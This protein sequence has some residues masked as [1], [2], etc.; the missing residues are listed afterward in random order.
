L[1]AEEEPI[2]YIAL[3]LVNLIY[4]GF[5]IFMGFVTPALLLVDIQISGILVN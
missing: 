3:L 5:G 4:T 1:D 2:R